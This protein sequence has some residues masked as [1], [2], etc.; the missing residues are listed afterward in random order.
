MMGAMRADFETIAEWVPKGSRV[1]DLG[2]GEGELLALLHERRQTRGVGL[3]VSLDAVTGCIGRG[4]SAYQG[5][6]D[7]GLADLQSASYD[8]VILNQVL[9]SVREPR[10]VME[11]AARVGRKVIVGFPNFG[12]IGVRWQVLRGRTPRTRN[13]P[14]EWYNSPNF[15]FLSLIDFRDFLHRSKLTILREAYF[16]DAKPISLFPNLMATTCLIEI[17]SKRTHHG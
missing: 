3:E 6:L 7:Q 15:H 4:V 1:L 14:Y 13:L 16:A 2:C 8:V 5:D 9:Q 17:E 10:M 12:Y 11:E